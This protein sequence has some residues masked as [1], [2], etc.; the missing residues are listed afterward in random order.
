MTSLCLPFCYFCLNMRAVYCCKS[1]RVHLSQSEQRTNELLRSNFFPKQWSML[2]RET[3]KR[4][5]RQHQSG[6]GMSPGKTWPVIGTFTL[7]HHTHIQALRSR[8][9][10]ICKIFWLMK[11]VHHNLVHNSLYSFKT[12]EFVL[13]NE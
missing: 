10:P 11:T 6:A 5:L 1:S 9:T 12:L 4:K 2:E 3:F 13:S 8:M 7:V